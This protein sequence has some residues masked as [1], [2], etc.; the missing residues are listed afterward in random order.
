MGV[1]LMLVTIGGLIVAAILLAVSLLTKKTWL[2]KFAI[3]GVAVWFLFYAVMLLGFSFASTEKTLAMNEP[4]EY[5]GFYLDCHLHTVV[6]GVRTTKNIGSLTAKGQFYVVMVKVFS[7]A[8]NP[9]IAF[10]LLK[11]K[12][13]V[14]D[15]KGTLYARNDEAEK[16]LPS[17]GAQLDQ[18]IKGSETIQKEI[19]F[20]LPEGV[21]N[22]RLDISEGYGVD[23]Y[24]EAALV[25]DEDSILHKRTYFKL[26]EQ[27]VARSVK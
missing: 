8:K 18:D 19:V 26:G 5:C 9:A 20:D 24:I 21:Q 17:A 3:G 22:P 27:S 14:I 12:T 11:P 10:R 23:K 6:T 1:L 13:V 25:D 7:D 15:E 16:L 2:T 4:K